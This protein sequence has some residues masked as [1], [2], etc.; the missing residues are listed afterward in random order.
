MIINKLQ[1][2][3]MKQLQELKVGL[4][5]TMTFRGTEAESHELIHTLIIEE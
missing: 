2:F 4:Q 1:L 5:N 3:S